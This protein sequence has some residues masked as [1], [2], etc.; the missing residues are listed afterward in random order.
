MAYDE[1]LATRIRSH[2]KGRTDVTERN[3]TLARASGAGYRAVAVGAQ[4][5]FVAQ[6]LG[7]RL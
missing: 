1:G 7:R 4:T 2:F 3:H 5:A 6:C